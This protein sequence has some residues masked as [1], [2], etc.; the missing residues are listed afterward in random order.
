M[1]MV[2]AWP[3]RVRCLTY[4]LTISNTGSGTAINIPVDEPD[5]RYGR[6]L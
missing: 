6:D 4:T 3:N 2:M 1:P 5:H